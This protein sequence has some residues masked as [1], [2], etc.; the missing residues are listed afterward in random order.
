[1]RTIFA[2]DSKKMKSLAGQGRGGERTHETFDKL[3]AKPTRVSEKT[4][5]HNCGT[6]WEE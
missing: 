6:R 1:M 2:Q 5:T 3:S 4:E